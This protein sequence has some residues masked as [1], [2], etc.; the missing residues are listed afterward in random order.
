MKAK[1]ER[2]LRRAW[3]EKIEDDPGLPLE[4]LPYDSPYVMDYTTDQVLIAAICT[5]SSRVKENLLV[6][7]VMDLWSR[8]I[9]YKEYAVTWE[10][11]GKEIEEESDLV[12]ICATFTL[13]QQFTEKEASEKKDKSLEEMVP[14]E[15]IGYQFV[16]DTKASEWLLVIE[17]RGPWDHAI[18]LKEGAIPKNC[19]IYLLLPVKQ[20]TL[21]AFLKEQLDK[22][23]TRE[24][25]S[26]MAAPFFFIKKKDGALQL[27]QD[28]WYLNSQMVKNTY[29]LPLIPELIDKLKGATMF[30]KMDIRWEYNNIQIREEEWKA[31]F[32]TNKK[33]FEFT[34]MFS[35]L[36]NSLATFWLYMNHI[37]ADI[38]EEGHD[39]I[40]MDNILVFTR[41]NKKEH[42]R[43]VLKVL[44]RLKQHNL[45]VKLKKCSW[46][47]WQIEY[48]R[49][50]I[51]HNEVHMDLVKVN[52][53]AE[54][55][56]STI[57]K[58]VQ[59]FLE[60]GNF[61]CWFIKDFSTM[62]RLLYDLTK[63]GI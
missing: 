43:L 16:F 34:V 25:K 2:R 45:F 1:K 5:M 19:K 46:I 31:A 17:Q 12:W 59:S 42:D 30:S 24:S 51:S 44:K 22:G 20:S 39:I 4:A 61:Y 38:I 33:L 36:T 55:S 48:L 40:Y 32:K 8:R 28:Y 52:G 27:I 58:Q 57:V 14:L 50:I 21:N 47:Q 3:V 6:E 35:R 18:D 53:L 10:E 41:D 13:A 56:T 63:K 37:F 60:F 49:L 15:Y 7:T 11:M 29:P 62:A 54:W 26:P 23:Y 9:V